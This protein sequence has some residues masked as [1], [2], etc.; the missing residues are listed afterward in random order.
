[1]N[2]KD[3]KLGYVVRL[4]IGGFGAVL[5]VLLALSVY[6]AWAINGKY[7][8]YYGWARIEWN[9]ILWLIGACYFLLVCFLGKWRLGRG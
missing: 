5:L 6:A 3:Q 7:F 4:L 8:H 9:Y 1:V 2:T